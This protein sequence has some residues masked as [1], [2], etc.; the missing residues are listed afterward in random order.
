MEI[1]YRDFI[2]SM[3]IIALIPARM[4]SSRYPGKPMKKIHGK[5]MIGR[6]YER[7]AKATHET[8]EHP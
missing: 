8:H 6:V 2:F 1:H 4:A 7:V 3:K 5:P